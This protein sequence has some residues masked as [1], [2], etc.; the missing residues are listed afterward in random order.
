MVA[1]L[2][3]RIFDIALLFCTMISGGDY[4]L[5]RLCAHHLSPRSKACRR[6]R[7]R[8]CGRVRTVRPT[9]G[10]RRSTP[11]QAPDPYGRHVVAVGGERRDG[12]KTMIAAV[13]LRIFATKR[14]SSFN[15]RCWPRPARY[16]RQFKSCRSRS[17]PSSAVEETRLEGAKGTLQMPR[18]S[19]RSSPL[20]CK[21]AIAGR[22]VPC[23]GRLDGS[24][25]NSQPSLL[26]RAFVSGSTGTCGRAPRMPTIIGAATGRGRRGRRIKVAGRSKTPRTYSQHA[27]RPGPPTGL[28][29]MEHQPPTVSTRRVRSACERDLPAFR[30]IPRR[31]HQSRWTGC[32]QRLAAPGRSGRICLCYALLWLASDEVSYVTAASSMST[33]AFRHNSFS[34]RQKGKTLWN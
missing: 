15:S 5:S 34:D 20:V 10:E 3:L 30:A 2:S 26:A 29:R 27:K 16:R 8:C 31:Y 28:W 19:S 7:P 23:T 13:V 11:A 4:P 24:P 33:A 6:T 12:P 17:G 32:T 21:G 18:A 25:R 14:I 9:R 1:A 22:R